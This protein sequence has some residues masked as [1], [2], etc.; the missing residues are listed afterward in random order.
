[1]G[2]DEAGRGPLAGPVAVGVVLAPAFFDIK[3]NFPGVAD[4]KVLS[5]KKREELFSLLQSYTDSGALRY[6]VVFASPKCIDTQG[7]TRAVRSC[8]YKGVRTL[9]PEP[10]D[11]H[12]LLDGLLHA[13]PQY[14]QETIIRGDATEPIIS[15][16]SIAAKV[17]RDRLMH[18][19]AQRYPGYGFENHVGYATREHRDAIMQ[20]GLCDIH[21]VTYCHFKSSASVV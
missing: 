12:I 18:K 21:R 19:M 15:L 7:I 14:S 2:I 16:A 5:P 6:M 10:D 1:M 4:S 20:L 8:I 11:H 3:E 17:M 9:A 13:P